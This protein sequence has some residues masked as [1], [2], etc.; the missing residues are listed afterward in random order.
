LGYSVWGDGNFIYLANNTRGIEVYSVDG[1]GTLTHVDNDDQGG[2][3]FGVWGDGNFIYLA[4][5]DRG[6]E[7][8]SV[9]GAGILTHVDNDDMG[10]LAL[11][12]WGDGNFIYL[13]NY[14]R[15]I[16]VYSIDGTTAKTGVIADAA[17]V[18]IIDTCSVKE[19]THLG[20]DGCLVVNAKNGSIQSWNKD[21]GFNEN[22]PAGY[23]FQIREASMFKS[24]IY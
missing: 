12:V 6:I 4:N 14:D 10:G 19:V 7:V 8:Y 17:F 23:T 9:D 13:A 5:Y 11:G 18:G 2:I 24:M 1:A 20:T 3:A 21:A 15:G 16:E 22:D